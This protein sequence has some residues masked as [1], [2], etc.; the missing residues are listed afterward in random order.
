MPCDKALV[1]G[2]STQEYL[3]RTVPARALP[4]P[5]AASALNEGY[6][7]DFRYV[8]SVKGTALSTYN[9]VLLNCIIK[10]THDLQLV[11]HRSWR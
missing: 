4:V 10:G 5:Q 1:I 8:P 2:L 7:W 6:S 3:I 11:V 9:G